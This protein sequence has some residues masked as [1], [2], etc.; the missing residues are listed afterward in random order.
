MIETK[1]RWALYATVG[2]F[3]WR[4]FTDQSKVF[5]TIEGAREWYGNPN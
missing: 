3:Q 2:G 4:C 1:G 5:E